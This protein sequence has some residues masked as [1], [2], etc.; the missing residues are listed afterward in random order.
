[1]FCSFTWHADIIGNKLMVPRL[2]GC[3]DSSRKT[4]Q[5]TLTSL[6]PLRTK[7]FSAESST[8]DL[9]RRLMSITNQL[10]ARIIVSVPRGL[11]GQ[12]KIDRKTL[13]KAN[14]E[15]IISNLHSCIHSAR[16]TGG[17]TDREPHVLVHLDGVTNRV[18]V[19][20]QIPVIQGV[21]EGSSSNTSSTSS[22]RSS[23]AS[24]DLPHLLNASTE[25]DEFRKLR[26]QDKTLWV[27]GND[28]PAVCNQR[29]EKRKCPT[30]D[31]CGTSRNNTKQRRRSQPKTEQSCD[32]VR[33]SPRK[34][35]LSEPDA[36]TERNVYPKRNASGDSEYN[37]GPETNV[38]HKPR[39]TETETLLINTTDSNCG[40]ETET[41]CHLAEKT[42]TQG[43]L[44]SK[45]RRMVKPVLKDDFIYF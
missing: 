44:A 18:K 6:V 40:S 12:P 31:P 38:D 39:V 16:I 23:D 42:D 4:V 5:W 26:L 24:A 45:S 9:K 30:D 28:Y 3:T 34:R 27:D 19:I 8:G 35:R 2:H 15:H 10:H 41:R 37:G 21:A 29:S 36:N 13:K 1:M 43:G 11:S 33:T 22:T 32:V 25:W 7:P 14:L 20:E 17:P